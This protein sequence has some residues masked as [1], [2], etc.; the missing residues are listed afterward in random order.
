VPYDHLH[1]SY[2]ELL[3][4]FGLVGAALAAVLLGLLFRATWRAWRQGVL[5]EDHALW[6]VGT[7]AFTAVWCLTDFRSQHH[8]WRYFWLLLAG[9]AYAATMRRTAA[10][11]Q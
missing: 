11:A 4:R 5:P 2:L 7:L 6:L 1:N 8:D 9:S 3:V 10:R